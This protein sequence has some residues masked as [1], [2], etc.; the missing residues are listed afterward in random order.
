[1]SIKLPQDKIYKVYVNEVLVK[2]YRYWVQA[3]TYCL[4]NGY[5]YTGSG[6]DEWN[7][8]YSITSLDPR[9]KIVKE[10]DDG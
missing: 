8:G 1:M 4:M 2:E 6:T 10:E 5:V 3:V 9:V 7:F